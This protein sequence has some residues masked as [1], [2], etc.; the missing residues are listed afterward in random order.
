VTVI[1]I[2]TEIGTATATAIG[3]GIENAT[4]ETVIDDRGLD[5]ETVAI[6]VRGAVLQVS[7]LATAYRL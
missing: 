3:T 1:G 4:D 2:A 6:E 5:Q 7:I